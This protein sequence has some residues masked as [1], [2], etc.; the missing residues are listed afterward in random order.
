YKSQQEFASLFKNIPEALVYTDKKSDILYVNPRFTELFGYTL[1]EIKGKNIDEGIIHTQEK[2][3]E[4]KYYTKKSLNHFVNYETYRKRKDGSIF[5]VSISASSIKVNNKV[6]GII[7]LYQDITER[8]KAEEKLRHSEE[9]FAGIF[10]NIPDAAFF[11]DTR[12]IILDVNPHFIR[13]F[14]YTKEEMLGKNIDEIGFY[15][16]DKMKEGKDLTRKTLNEDLT[17]FETIRQKK[18]GTPVPVRI[19]TSFVKIKDKVTGVIALYQDITERK[20]NEKLQEVLYN[21]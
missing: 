9:K 15:P 10:K 4:G 21:I 20:Q 5:Q 3:D 1:D 8:K 7:I 17:N 13:L 14:G 18:D 19:S 12:G 11:Q 6:K 2:I 16:K